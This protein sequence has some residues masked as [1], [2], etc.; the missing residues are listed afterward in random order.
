MSRFGRNGIASNSPVLNPPY[1]AHRVFQI[2]TSYGW[3]AESEVSDSPRG[4]DFVT[5]CED[6]RTESARLTVVMWPYTATDKQYD[7]ALAKL[8]SSTKGKGRLWITDSKISHADDTDEDKL[9]P[10]EWMRF[11]VEIEL[12][13]SKK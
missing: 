6:L 4:F 1:R 8:G 3:T 12:P 9:G 13:R 11:S 2:D 5:N 10:I 7:E